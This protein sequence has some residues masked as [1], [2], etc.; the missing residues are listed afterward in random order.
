[1]G[2][3]Q[4]NPA[5]AGRLAE[6]IASGGSAIEAILR[7]AA[8]SLSVVSQEL[9][10]AI[11]PR[12]DHAIL[13]R[14]ELVRVSQERLLLILT[15]EGGAVSTIFVEVSG[16]VAESAL[17]EVALVLNNRLAGLS[18]REVRSSLGPR[19]RDSSQQPDARE[20]LNVFVQEGDTL[21][22]LPLSAREDEVV[23]GQASLLAGQPEFTSGE[24]LRRLLAL[25]ET[26]EDLAGILRRRSLAPGITITIGTEN[27]DPRLDQFT[28]VT[29]EYRSGA[30][31]GVIGVIGPTR[32]PYDKVVALVRHT[33]L[34]VSD[35]LH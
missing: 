16:Q 1:M 22:D 30:L 29:T 24:S 18:L 19:L 34:L 35:I 26:R 13:Q 23:L 31:A 6:E 4:L 27:T 5:E 20:L 10:V 9:G 21:F 32:M 7:R 8:Q 11:G 2:P 15:L 25:T 28:V 14:L 33:S 17:A 12:L 3:A